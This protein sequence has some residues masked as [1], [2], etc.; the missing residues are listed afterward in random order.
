MPPRLPLMVL[1]RLE[2]MQKLPTARRPLEGPCRSYTLI[3]NPALQ[4]R[5]LLVIIAFPG[6]I[7]AYVKS[8][9]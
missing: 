3:G 1:Q 7:T 9:G 6:S 4:A 2:V 5:R 8:S